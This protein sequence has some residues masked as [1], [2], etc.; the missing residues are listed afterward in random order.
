MTPSCE[1][2]RGACCEE[3][4][5][6]DEDLNLTGDERTWLRLHGTWSGPGWPIT[7]ATILECRCRALG[8]DGRC[9]V[10]LERPRVCRDFG[11]GSEEC[12]EKIR[13]R[14]PRYWKELA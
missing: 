1:E 11:L 7:E 8:D 6:K 2:C 4:T 9:K 14:R 13:R 12:L 5:L 10:Y 3:V